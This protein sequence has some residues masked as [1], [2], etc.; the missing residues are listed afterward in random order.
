MGRLRLLRLV[1]RP[2][3]GLYTSARRG[4]PM[5]CLSLSVQKVSSTPLSSLSHRR[6]SSRSRSSSWLCGLRTRSSSSTRTILP[7]RSS[8][9]CSFLAN[10]FSILKESSRNSWSNPLKMLLPLCWLPLSLRLWPSLC[11]CLCLPPCCCSC[12]CCGFPAR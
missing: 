7:L 8:R 2:P 10:S 12:C 9:L 5:L 1:M 4:S 3:R 11:L 6:H